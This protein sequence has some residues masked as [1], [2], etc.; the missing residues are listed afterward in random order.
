MTSPP[1]IFVQ[2]FNTKHES[3][4]RAS[5]S[6]AMPSSTIRGPMSIPNSRGEPPP[7]PLPPPT[8]MADIAAGSDP[9][10]MW[11]NKFGEQAVGT[12]RGSMSAGS[13]MPKGWD[14]RRE[15][16]GG[17]DRP[18][19]SRRGSS[20]STVK[21][22][23]QTESKYAFSHFNDEGYYSVSGPSPANH[24]S[25]YTIPL[26]VPP[27]H[28]PWARRIAVTLPRGASCVVETV[29][30]PPLP[31]RLTGTNHAGQESLG[32]I[33]ATNMIYIQVDGAPWHQAFRATEPRE[34]VPCL[35]QQATL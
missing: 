21:P 6:A 33:L 11:G 23:L 12:S 24:Q 15:G 1:S 2:N 17:A 14:R 18:D 30:P 35:R 19:Y 29:N 13:R 28:P 8:H 3:H 9:G 10:W 16:D 20:Q 7:P 4:R 5:P 32:S 25:V 26:L 22:P 34:L 27:H 31:P